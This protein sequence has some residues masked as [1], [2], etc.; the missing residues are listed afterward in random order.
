MPNDIMPITN[1]EVVLYQP[2]EN[3]QLDVRISNDTGRLC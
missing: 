1:A 3:I 2:D